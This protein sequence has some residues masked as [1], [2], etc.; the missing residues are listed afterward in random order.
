MESRLHRLRIIL[1]QALGDRRSPGWPCFKYTI[2]Y[3]KRGTLWL[4]RLRRRQ[5]NKGAGFYGGEGLPRQCQRF[6]KRSSRLCRSVFF[7][8]TRVVFRSFF[9]FC[10]LAV[11]SVVLSLLRFVFSRVFARSSLVRFVSFSVCPL[12]IFFCLGFVSCSVFSLLFFWFCVVVLPCCSFVRPVVRY[13]LRPFVFSLC[14]FL[15]LGVAFF[16]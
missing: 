9:C 4:H 2:V 6:Q 3:Y 10:Y 15:V 7:V 16:I 11:L 14:V 8:V 5:K 1:R 12:L 13:V